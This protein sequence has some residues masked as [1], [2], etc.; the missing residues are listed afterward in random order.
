[1]TPRPAP[2][3]SAWCYGDPGVAVALLLAARD[4][5][6]PGWELAATE[7]AL[8]AAAAQPSSPG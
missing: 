7:L 3:R 5:D 4:V 2:A 6:E 8:R 1:M